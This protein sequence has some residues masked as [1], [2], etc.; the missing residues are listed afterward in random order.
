MSVNWL[1]IDWKEIKNIKEMIKLEKKLNLNEFETALKK[2]FSDFFPIV[3]PIID[4]VENAYASKKKDA[5]KINCI[6]MVFTA[7]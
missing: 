4:S 5:N 2:F 7:K 3:Q 1:T 6:S